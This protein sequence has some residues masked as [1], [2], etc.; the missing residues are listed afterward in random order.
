LLGPLL[1]LLLL[2][3]QAFQL[4][5]LVWLLFA[6]QA[7]PVPVPQVSPVFAKLAFLASAPPVL[8]GP[9]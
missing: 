8:R 7:W 5:A 9:Q 2:T 6:L 4:A 3:L 1:A